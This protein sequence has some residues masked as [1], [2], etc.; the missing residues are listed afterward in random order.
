MH[1]PLS[2]SNEES[3]ANGLASKYRNTVPQYLD[4]ADRHSLKEE[5]AK[6]DLVIRYLVRE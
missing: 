3:Q 1:S 5:I 6:H 4:I 2:A